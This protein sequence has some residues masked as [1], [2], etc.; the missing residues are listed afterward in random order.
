MDTPAS[1][2]SA[3]LHQIIPLL[4]ELGV[5]FWLGRGVLRH[6]ILQKEIG[7]KQS[8]LDFHIWEKDKDILKRLVKSFAGYNF[9]TKHY[10]STLTNRDEKLQVEFMYLWNY[11][12]NPNLVYHERRNG[13][14]YFP[15]DC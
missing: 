1:N 12:A 10:K 14:F 13:K 9:S 11:S 7:D 4:E 8:D 6:W 15:A 2:I 3:L 5:N